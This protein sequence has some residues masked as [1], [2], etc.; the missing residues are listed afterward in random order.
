VWCVR[1]GVFVILKVGTW[2]VGRLVELLEDAFNGVG[3][4]VCV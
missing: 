2:K 3:V 1:G 4:C